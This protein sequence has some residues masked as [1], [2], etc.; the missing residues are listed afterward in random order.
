MTDAG[1]YQARRQGLRFREMHPIARTRSSRV[2]FAATLILAQ[3]ACV[4]REMPVSAPPSRAAFS[5]ATIATGAELAALGDCVVCHTTKEGRPYAGGR[6]IPTP[7]G[8]VF[9]TNITPDRATG[10]GDWSPEA[11]RRAMRDGIDRQGRHLYP[12]LPYPH[13]IRATDDDI[14]ALYAFLM[15][16]EPVSQQTPPN[17]L[18]FPANIR[19]LL[20]GWKALFLRHAPF[21]P[22]PARSADWNRGA[23]LVDAIGHCGACHTPHNFLG[24]EKSG[25][26]LAGGEAEGWYAPALRSDSPAPRPWS[27]AQLTT[28]LRTGV[29]TDHGVAAGPM[30]PVTHQLEAVPDQD[31]HAMAVYIASLMPASTNTAAQ[32]PSAPRPVADEHAAAM[33]DGACGACHATDAPMTRGGAPP[34]SVSSA[35]NAPTSRNVVDVI[36]HGIPLRESHTGPYMPPFSSALTDAQVVT[37]TGYVRARYSAGPEWTDIEA[38]VREARHQGGGS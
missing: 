8:T 14:S 12:V 26:T 28:Y 31:V 15:T 36:L 37:L 20:A 10:I 32:V 38:T 6:G 18:S 35:V 4:A 3:S 2:L 16:R 33:F 25:R 13:F 11:F 5:P 21:Q 23:Y 9:A 22:D 19:P 27:V 30:A 34:L 7:F 17:K 29:E 24:A 1:R